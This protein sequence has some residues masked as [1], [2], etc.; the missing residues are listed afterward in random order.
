MQRPLK[1]E[2]LNGASCP[3]KG[4]DGPFFLPDAS[5][6]VENDI[7]GLWNCPACL[8]HVVLVKLSRSSFCPMHQLPRIPFWHFDGTS[9]YRINLLNI[10]IQFI[11]W[12]KQSSVGVICWRWGDNRDILIENGLWLYVYIIWL[13]STTTFFCLENNMNDKNKLKS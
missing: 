12:K 9:C 11:D 7:M 6:P 2:T 4:G 3:V 5:R 10:S 1:S 13:A 8:P